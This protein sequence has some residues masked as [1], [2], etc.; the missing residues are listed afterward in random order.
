M[1]DVGCAHRQEALNDPVALAHVVA[2]LRGGQDK[3][4][5]DGLVQGR[6]VAPIPQPQVYLPR[7]Q[8][9]LDHLESTVLDGVQERRVVEDVREH[10]VDVGAF[11][12]QSAQVQG[13]LLIEGRAQLETP[14]TGAIIRVLLPANK[15]LNTKLSKTKF[16]S[17]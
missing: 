1:R 16:K 7:L 14:F 5:P 13:I 4:R 17:T 9:G 8:Q 15:T 2:L 6:V 10:G 11:T 12:E 3:P